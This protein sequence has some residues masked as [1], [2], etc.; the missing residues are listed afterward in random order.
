MLSLGLGPLLASLYGPAYGP[1]ATLLP[2]LVAGTIPFAVTMTL[3]TTARIR[4]HSNAT[5]AVAVA[6]AVAVLVPTVLLTASDGALGAA[7]GW[8]IGNAIAAVVALLASRLP[9]RERGSSATGRRRRLAYPDPGLGAGRS[10]R[11]SSAGRPIGSRHAGQDEATSVALPDRLRRAPTAVRDW[12]GARFGPIELVLLATLVVLPAAFVWH[13][14]SPSYF[15]SDDFVHFYAAHT[16]S[17]PVVVRLRS[18]LRVIWPPL[19]PLTYL[20]LDRAAPLNFEVA[21]A[22]LVVCHAV[23]A[24]LLQ[25]ILTLLFGRAWW[26]YALALAWAISPIYLP[27]FTWVAAGLHSIPAI[28]ATLA[29]IHGYLC[30]RATGRGWWLAWSLVAM[31]VGLG[32]YVKALLIPFYLILMRVLLL[33]P[34]ARLRDSL[35]SVR[36]SGGCGSPT[37]PGVRCS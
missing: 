9:G 15:F 8:T 23:S 1:V 3:L 5:I 19:T 25:R 4:E 28:T 14:A 13:F 27:P 32:F 10:R 35:R 36:A 11:M 6:F 29:S 37:R 26:T 30:W 2:L 17:R 16:D 7:W 20:V 12:L 18:D 33:D 24:V 34:A 22:G 31:V 21:L